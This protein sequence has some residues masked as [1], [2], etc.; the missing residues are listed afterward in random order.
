MKLSFHIK[1][2]SICSSGYIA[3]RTSRYAQCISR[4]SHYILLANVTGSTALR[5]TR[6]SRML[7]KIMERCVAQKVD[8]PLTFSNV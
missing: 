5:A 7:F 4:Q 8:A 6:L 1:T 3:V 2:L